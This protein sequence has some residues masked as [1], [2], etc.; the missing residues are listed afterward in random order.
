M[1][2]FL[3]ISSTSL[4]ELIFLCE[5]TLEK[6]GMRATLGSGDENYPTGSSVATKNVSC[7]DEL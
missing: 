4:M 7:I 2:V 3:L 1:L 6:G 5:E